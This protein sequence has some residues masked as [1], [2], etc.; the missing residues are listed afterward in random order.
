MAKRIRIAN[1]F[2]IGAADVAVRHNHAPDD[3]IGF[4][5]EVYKPGETDSEGK[6][7]VG[8]VITF[9][10]SDFPEVVQVKAMAMGFLQKIGDAYA[11]SKNKDESVSDIIETMGERLAAGEWVLKGTG[12]GPR[13]SML[14]EAFL[15]V[16]VAQKGLASVDDL[17]EDTLAKVTE[18]LST[19]EGQD[20]AMANLRIKA[21]YERLKA[22]RAAERAAAAAKAAEGQDD[23]ETE[24]DLFAGM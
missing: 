18:T 3:V 17:A 1:K 4:G 9:N 16:L 13:P 21:E 2:Y 12:T 11:D 22:E 10:H 19:K 6:P 15:N 7:I 24:D 23:A 20:Q 5:F 14:R 8:D